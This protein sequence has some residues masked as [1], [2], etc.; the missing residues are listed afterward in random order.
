L[1]DSAD[2]A[3]S[4]EARARVPIVPPVFVEDMAASIAVDDTGPPTQSEAAKHGLRVL[5]ILSTLLGFAS[6]STDL[7]LP[8]LPSMAVALHSDP[9]TMALTISGYLVGF[10][11]GQLLW[12]P[13]G[14]RYGRRL[15]V[16]IGLALFVIG[17]AACALSTSAWQ[18]IGWRVVQAVGACAGVVLAR[19]M[20][21]DMYRG[22]RA[23][24]MLSTLMAV[25][26]IAPLLG[27]ALGGQILRLASWRAIFWTLLAV[28]LATLVALVALPETLPP[29]R[30][31][32]DSL[33]RALSGYWLLLR[34]P[35]V[36]GFAGAGGFFY[37]GIYAYIA[38]TPFAYISYYHLPA[39]LY[40]V[41]FGSNVA[42]IMVTNL[43]NA[44]L[45]LRLGSVRLLRVG[46][47]GAALA[48]ILLA[49]DAKKGWGGLMG[50]AVPLFLYISC[51]GFIVANSISGA[52][53]TCPERAGAGSALVGSIHYGIGII[54]SAMVGAFADGTSWPMGWVV[55]S[56]G[57]G[58]ALCAWVLVP[59]SATTALI[60]AD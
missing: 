30:R 59:H 11:L 48:A 27:P 17:S 33:W 52:L 51:F 2:V 53:A 31:N 44:R 28:G 8:A 57:I 32:R 24:Q 45:V 9:G 54:G 60:E 46:T 50:L 35:G 47:A 5:L 37:G 4:T 34:R 41:L 25:M 23:A 55:A 1:S 18:I 22:D 13:I 58:S 43:V 40:G 15:P 21:R 42:G 56:A 36:I 3:A 49:I 6:I 29:E 7:Y 38:G 20:V 26:A 12:G 10:S 14:D 16:A 19:A 39:Q